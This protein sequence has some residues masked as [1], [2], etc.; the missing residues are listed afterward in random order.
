[1]WMLRV[2]TTQLQT[3]TFTKAAMQLFTLLCKIIQF[4]CSD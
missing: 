2:A 4:E 3:F 1:M